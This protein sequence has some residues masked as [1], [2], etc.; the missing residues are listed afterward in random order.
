MAP[1]LTDRF[2][3]PSSAHEVGREAVVTLLGLGLSIDYGLLLVNRYR[4]EASSGGPPEEAL[5]RAWATA[6]RTIL[7]SALTVAA[8]LSGLL[9]FDLPGL[10]TLGAAGISLAEVAMVVALQFP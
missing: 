9:M 2:G 10:S 4:Q 6:G 3:N 5:A 8:A 1:Y 7:F